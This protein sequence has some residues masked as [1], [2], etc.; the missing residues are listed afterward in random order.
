MAR[1]RG[2]QNLNEE[3]PLF[4]LKHELTVDGTRFELGDPFPW[5]ELAGVTPRLVRQLHDQRKIGHERPE[6]PPAG[7]EDPQR[8][9]RE[10]EAAEARD[11]GRKG[12]KAPPVS[13]RLG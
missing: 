5:Q 6:A 1:I 8:S 4:V 11:A 12:K 3:K 7:A 13:A 2:H 10:Q 9:P